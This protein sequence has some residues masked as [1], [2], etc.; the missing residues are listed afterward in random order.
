[1]NKV[2]QIAVREFVATVFTKGFIIALLIVPA[3]FGLMAV[4]G[5]RLFGNAT[6]LAVE[7]EIAVVDATGVVLP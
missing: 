5:P 3:I 7:G 4:F 2:L 6:N 1:M